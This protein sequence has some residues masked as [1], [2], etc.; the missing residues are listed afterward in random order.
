MTRES[1]RRARAAFRALV[2]RLAPPGG[3]VFDFGAGAGLDTKYFAEHGLTVRAY[4]NDPRMS[5]FLAHHCHDLIESGR[6]ELE[7][8]SYEEFLARGHA[9]EEERRAA[10]VAANFAPLNLI[11]DLPILFARLHSLTAPEG[12][13]V[14]SV[15]N[16]FFI[17]DAK[18]GWWWRNL[19]RLWRI[20]RYALEGA[21]GE[22]VR[23]T[24]A[25]FAAQCSPWFTLE[26]LHRGLPPRGSRE[27]AGF[28]W[29]AGRRAAWMPRGCQFIFLV[30]R[31]RELP[32]E[33]GGTS[34]AKRGQLAASTPIQ[35]L[36]ARAATSADSARN[37]VR[38]QRE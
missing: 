37:T 31:R 24:P 33:G 16:P 34:G 32:G 15:L 18:Y 8:G 30:F 38:L 20:G 4:D 9:D 29:P 14:A 28:D 27:A 21:D 19:P 12:R 11:A 23:R 25:D 3:V 22:I 13:V 17:W 35:S 1:D 6:V 7:T 5:A 10:L 2:M 36:P 26:R